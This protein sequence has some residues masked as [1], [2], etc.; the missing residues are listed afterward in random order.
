MKLYYYVFYRLYIMTKWIDD[1]LPQWWAS[2]Q[3]TVIVMLLTGCLL[4]FIAPL[5]FEAAERDMTKFTAALQFLL[6]LLPNYFLFIAGDRYKG[7]VKL[8]EGES[9]RA[10]ILGNVLVIAF[11]A[12]LTSAFMSLA[13]FYR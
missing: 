11:I 6:F 10:T 12:L 13:R 7:I 2:V 5:W 4:E 8:F 3:L 1:S 9:R